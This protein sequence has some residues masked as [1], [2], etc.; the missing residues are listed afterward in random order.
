MRLTITIAA[1]I[2]ASA[3]FTASAISEEAIQECDAVAGTAIEISR[4]YNEGHSIFKMRD[5][6]GV[7]EAP[8]WVQN[9]FYEMVDVYSDVMAAWSHEED[10][11][12]TAYGE[13]WFTECMSWYRNQSESSGSATIRQNAAL[14][15]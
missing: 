8:S 12:P 5:D 4:R 7:D 13:F 2:I 10:Y 6:L 3:P 14:T 15:F 9:L 1:G 11:P